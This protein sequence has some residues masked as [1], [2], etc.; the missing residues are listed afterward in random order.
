MSFANSL[1]DENQSLWQQMVG[2]RLVDE[3]G[4]GTL[5]AEAFQRYIEQDYLFVMEFARALAVAASKAPEL[6]TAKRLLDFASYVLGGGREFFVGALRQLDLDDDQ[7]SNLRPA[8]T[9]L[10]FI[11]H[12]HGIAQRGTFSEL[13]TA[14]YCLEA[15]YLAWG[16]R[17]VDDGVTAQQPLYREWI[18]IH[19]SDNLASFVDWLRTLVDAAPQDEHPRLRQV[20]SD[21]LALEIRFWDMAYDGEDW[22]S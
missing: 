18:E 19:A 1:Q 2:H 3:L 7:I 15:T 17:L 8:P 11:D 4:D 9:C 14:V 22:P 6:D 21:C 12:L 10:A 5:P 16:K 20:F 13:M